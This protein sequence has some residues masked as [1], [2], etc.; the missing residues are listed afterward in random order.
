[1]LRVSTYFLYYRIV[2][3][4]KPYH[5]GNLKSV[6]ARAALKLVG[7]TGLGAFTLREVARRAG[8]SHNAP[9]RHFKKKEDVFAALA[10]EGFLQLNDRLREALNLELDPAARLRGASR[11]YL[12]FAFENPAR[13]AVMF[14]ANFDRQAYEE[15]VSAYTESLRLLSQLIE[16]CGELGAE[17]AETAGEL[18][19]SG[20]H[21]IAELGLAQRLRGGDESDLEHL[22][23]SA[24]DSLL[25]GMPNALSKQAAAGKRKPLARKAS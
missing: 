7:E 11:A 19:W 3:E 5:H 21:G 4:K 9:Y 16:A 13:F 23:D 18:V 6:L 22:V 24:I 8:V 17:S 15:Y 20:V 12:H 10:S 25:N 14:H 1:M 2:D